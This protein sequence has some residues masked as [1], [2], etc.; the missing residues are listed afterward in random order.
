MLSGAITG[1][2]TAL[3]AYFGVKL[4]LWQIGLI[5]GAIKLLIIGV[6]MLAGAAALKKFNKKAPPKDSIAASGA[7]HET[8]GPEKSE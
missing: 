4:N 8:R 1:A 5:W 3:F 2:I 6:G 7:Q